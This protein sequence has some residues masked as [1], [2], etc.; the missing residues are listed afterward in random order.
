MPQMASMRTSSSVKV[1]RSRLGRASRATTRAV[2]E[3]IPA[4]I[5]TVGPS[6]PA[7]PPVPSVM[8]EVIAVMS[9]VRFGRRPPLSWIASIAR[10]VEPGL[11]N[12]SGVKRARNSPTTRPP[13]AGTTGS[14]HGVGR[15]AEAAA[16][17]PFIASSVQTNATAA[18]P[19]STPVSP[20]RTDHL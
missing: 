13:S 4:P 5:S 6:R 18:S 8:A 16:T 9:A 3:P 15:V 17:P 12:A 19:P 11:S 7:L 20:P 1:N 14:S 2:S 10:S